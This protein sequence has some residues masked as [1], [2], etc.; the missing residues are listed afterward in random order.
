MCYI[1]LKLNGK[2]GDKMNYKR[3]K[4]RTHVRCY[5][6]TDNRVG[7]NGRTKDLEEE[8]KSVPAKHPSWYCK[9]R[10]GKHEFILVKEEEFGILPGIWQTFRCSSCGKKKLNHLDSPTTERLVEQLY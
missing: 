1:I 5:Y 4:S 8:W 6:C 9:R 7:I 10:K 3:N 2:I